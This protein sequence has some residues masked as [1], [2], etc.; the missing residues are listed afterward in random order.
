[1]WRCSLTSV[2]YH[3]LGF[4]EL[5]L[6][7]PTRLYS[8]MFEHIQPKWLEDAHEVP[9]THF[10]S[11]ALLQRLWTEFRYD[12]VTLKFSWV[13]SGQYSQMGHEKSFTGHF[14]YIIRGHLTSWIRSYGNLSL[15][16]INY[17]TNKDSKNTKLLLLC[18]I[19]TRRP[20]HSVLVIS[21]CCT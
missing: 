12:S 11:K 18:N 3:D 13:F 17:C 1:M 19:A 4:V 6:Y 2:Q 9:V 20:F 21:L 15:R 8:L 10:V 14:R 16:T 5:F 7:G